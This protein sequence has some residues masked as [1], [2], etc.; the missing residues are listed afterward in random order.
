VLGVVVAVALAAAA[1]GTSGRELRAPAPDAVSPQRS[2]TPV[3]RPSTTTTTTVAA[4]ST[5]ALTS[6][7][8][9]DGAMLPAPF[10][11]EGPSPELRWT[12]VPGETAQLVLAVIDRDAQDAVQ[13]LVTGVAAADGS[14]GSGST[15][16]GARTLTNSFDRDG[17][18]GPCPPAGSTHHYDFVVLALPAP[19]TVPGSAPATEVY[20]RMRQAAA[21]RQAVLSATVSR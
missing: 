14:V 4:A 2:S 10:T 6:P 1:C 19:I 7:S 13:W 12:G 20:E 21:G 8:F 15:P 9:S 3:N 17:W 16:A 5:L 11:C 18:N